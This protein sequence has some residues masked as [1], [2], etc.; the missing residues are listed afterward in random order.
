MAENLDHASGSTAPVNMDK[1]RP[2]RVRYGFGREV[3]G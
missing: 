1:T 3:K 2:V